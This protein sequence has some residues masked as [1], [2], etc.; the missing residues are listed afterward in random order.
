MLAA[1]LEGL[2]ARAAALA[3][4]LAAAGLDAV[5]VDAEARVGG[6]GAPGAPAAQR[7][8]VAAGVASPSRCGGARRRSSGYVEGDRTLLNLRSVPPSA[9]DA[10]AAAVLEVRRT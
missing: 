6:G 8:G 2:R 5:A 7:R 1:D 4:R 10:L 3:A 9:D